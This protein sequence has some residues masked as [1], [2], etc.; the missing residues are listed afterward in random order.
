MAHA[1]ASGGPAE[2]ARPLSLIVRQ[3]GVRVAMATLIVAQV[4]MVMLMVI[5]S[6]HMKDHHH[7]LG[8]IAAVISSHVVGMYAF[9]VVPGRLADRSGRGRTLL[10]GATLL[11]LACLL[12]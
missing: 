4:V 2:A 3:R 11:G 8:R 10:C 9:S 12:A 6:L 1:A 5:T 7:P